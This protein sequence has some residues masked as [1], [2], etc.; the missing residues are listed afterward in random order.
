MLLIPAI[1]LKDGRCVR[2]LQGEADAQTIYSNDPVEMAISFEDA[3]AKRLHL[4]DLDGAFQGKGANMA[5]IRSILKNISIPVQ[6]GG[7]LRNAENIE[8]MFE[9]GVSSVIVSTMAVKN[10]EVL[11]EIILRYSGKRIFLGV[12]SRNRKVFIEGWQEGTE[13]DD[14]ELALLWK[15]HGIQRIV[16]TDIAR[17][18]MLSGPN[19]EALGDFA[20]RTGLK[21]VASGGVSS[22]EDLELLKTLEK[23]GVD[24]VISGKAIYEGKLNL[25][26]IFKF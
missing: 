9:L 11:E 5:I 12:D 23:D 4:V 2:L 22:M 16:F 1:D 15:K 18:G 7:G 14:V 6:L 20:R 8:Q 19:L 24:Q 10:S 13:I 17:D 21:I 26:E 25:K 3:G